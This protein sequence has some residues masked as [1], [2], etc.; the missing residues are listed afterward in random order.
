MAKVSQLEKSF[1][2]DIKETGKTEV[3]PTSTKPKIR[4]ND[5]LEGE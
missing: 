4:E 5:G 1:M 3:R 2:T